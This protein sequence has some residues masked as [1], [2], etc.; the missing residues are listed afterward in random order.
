MKSTPNV[1]SAAQCLIA[2]QQPVLRLQDL[3]DI[4]AGL[5]ERSS[6][7]L[8]LTDVADDDERLR[9]VV[10]R[11]YRHDN[12]FLKI[13]LLTRGDAKWRIHIWDPSS[14]GGPHVSNI[15]NHRWDS[16]AALLC[17]GY[18]QQMFLPVDESDTNDVVV[19]RHKYAPGS[20]LSPGGQLTAS[21]AVC[22]LRLAVDI[23][24]VAGSV[25]VADASTLHRVI[26]SS[27]IYTASVFVNG[28][29]K[30]D[31]TDVYSE[32]RLTRL[33]SKEN[34]RLTDRELR[35]AIRGLVERL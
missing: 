8:T 23:K 26:V 18:R 5:A 25:I 20:D 19:R 27:D 33:E 11:S 29:S 22:S 15:H 2:L 12:G 34:R 24:T 6:L 16:A 21:G 35:E 30:R 13:V 14:A 32:D 4:A 17:G 7:R 3:R 9:E 28:P 1:L 10:G 31:H